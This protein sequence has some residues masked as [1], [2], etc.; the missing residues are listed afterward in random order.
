MTPI[1]PQHAFF[2]AK[3]TLL[4]V[5]PRGELFHEQFH[6][7]GESSLVVSIWAIRDPE[8]HASQS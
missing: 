8:S 3:N 4:L 7:L 6:G 1:E 5:A 2:G